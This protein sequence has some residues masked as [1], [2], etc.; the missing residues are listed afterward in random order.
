MS[1]RTYIQDHPTPL[2]WAWELSER[3]LRFM[4]PL[5]EK[6]GLET[7]SKLVKVPEEVVK[8]LLFDCQDCAQ[9]MLHYNGMTCPMNCPKHLRNGP[10]GGVRLN[11]HCEVKPEMDCVWVK[12]IERAPKTPYAHE[13][14]R[15]NP[16][17]DIRLK[18]EASWVTYSLGLDKIGTGVDITPRYAYEALPETLPDWI[19]PKP[20]EHA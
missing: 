19:P 2:V 11:G 4:R 16:P 15:L 8:G 10:C 9:C 14:L 6:L 5:F 13:L 7:S 17:V 1:L 18:G 20:K 3:A 12:A